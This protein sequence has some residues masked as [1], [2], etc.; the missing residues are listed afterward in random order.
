MLYD[1]NLD[2][3]L[4]ILDQNPTV[5]SIFECYHVLIELGPN[6]PAHLLATRRLHDLASELD[7]A[8]PSLLKKVERLRL[9]LP[10]MVG[11][12]AKWL[13]KNVTQEG[14]TQLLAKFNESDEA[15]RIIR[16]AAAYEELLV[17]KPRSEY[18][19][20]S[21]LTTNLISH[22]L[23]TDPIAEF[24]KPAGSRAVDAATGLNMTNVTVTAT[25]PYTVLDA[26]LAGDDTYDLL[27]VYC[28][29]QQLPNKRFG[30]GDEI[31][32][33]KDYD[34]FD[35][36]LHRCL[37]TPRGWLPPPVG[38]KS[39]DI[40]T[41]LANADLSWLKHIRLSR[42]YHAEQIMPGRFW[43]EVRRVCVQSSNTRYRTP[44]E[45]VMDDGARTDPSARIDIR[46]TTPEVH[47]MVRASAAVGFSHVE[48][49][50]EI[51][52]KY[53][54][55][56][57]PPKETT[58]FYGESKLV[59]FA[60]RPNQTDRGVRLQSLRDN[61][62][63][64]LRQMD[65]AHKLSLRL[66]EL[67]KSFQSTYH[68]KISFHSK[69]RKEDVRNEWWRGSLKLQITPGLYVKGEIRVF[70]DPTFPIEGYRKQSHFGVVGRCVQFLDSDSNGKSE[71]FGAGAYAIGLRGFERLDEKEL[72]AATFILELEKDESGQL[73]LA[74]NHKQ[75]LIGLW[76]GRQT[77]VTHPPRHDMGVLIFHTKKNLE[78]PKLN[79]ILE[80]F[81][82]TNKLGLFTKLPNDVYGK[83]GAVA[84]T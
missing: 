77:H 51:D 53:I 59:L 11:L 71:S 2:W 20:L 72:V 45:P 19:Q 28:D 30:K 17:R 3:Q 47:A 27:L 23:L 55:F 8:P 9:H 13:D 49:L 18:K 65:Q 54:D 57:V 58:D 48:F 32:Y 79:E 69:G 73:Q 38:G 40:A 43:H 78:A 63:K 5:N 36:P 52:Q 26:I 67:L 21:V 34:R 64:H 6:K 16:L 61:I 25:E 84:T 70:S 66:T 1:D 33:I 50:S 7:L 80:E 15:S 14:W 46:R 35:F 62:E 37:I 29:Q 75:H 12:F 81:L 60:R 4:L 22:R 24:L 56:Y 76:T 42:T 68:T 74:P 82:A 31:E 83:E 10:M 41:M 44:D 39:S